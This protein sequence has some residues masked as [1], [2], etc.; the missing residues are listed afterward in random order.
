M[1][2]AVLSYTPRPQ[3]LPFHE[4]QQRWAIIVA[5][6]RAG[7]TVATINDLIFRALHSVKPDSRYA[8]VAPYYN[9]VKDLAWKYLKEYAWPVLKEPP[10]E[11]EVSVL[12]A[13]GAR[14][15][16]YGG[17]NPDRLRGIYLD[18]VVLDVGDMIPQLWSSVLRPA[19]ADRGGWATFIGTPKG[20]NQFWE[21]WDEAGRNKTWFTLMLKSSKTGILAPEEIADISANISPDEVEQEL[22]CSFEA[23]IKGAF[24]ADAMRVMLAEGRISPLEIDKDVLVYTAWD[25]GVSDSTAIWFIQ[26]VG[27]ERR[28]VDY[29]EA[30]GVG[31]EHYVDVLVERRLK[32]GYKYGQHFFPRDIKH[33]ELT[34]GKSRLTIGHFPFCMH[35]DRRARDFKHPNFSISP[36]AASSSHQ[37]ASL[38]GCCMCSPYFM[39]NR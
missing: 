34:T 38:P 3:F 10:R 13:N 24:Y 21:L 18:G 14:I 22:E 36:A 8:F 35:G 31:L 28:L 20:K 15:R 27:R 5:H 17:D 39:A 32:G 11:S 23:A 2:D 33:R 16:L 1:K 19:L 30:S 6:R 7:K 9:Q 26:C 12:L 37:A 4:R 25:L 29:Y